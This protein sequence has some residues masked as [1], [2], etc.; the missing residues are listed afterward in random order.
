MH[1][2]YSRVSIAVSNIRKK[3]KSI[4]NA[5]KAQQEEVSYSVTQNH[6]AVD[7]AALSPMHVSPLHPVAAISFEESEEFVFSPMHVG[8]GVTTVSSGGGNLAMELLPSAHKRSV[9]RKILNYN[10]SK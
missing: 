2:Y 1:F 10:R 8:G 9:L 3:I 4:S 7:V 6:E 5:K